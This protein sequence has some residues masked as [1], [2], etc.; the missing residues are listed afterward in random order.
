MFKWLDTPRH[1]CAIILRYFQIFFC[2]RIHLT[3]HRII[4][5]YLY[6]IMYNDHP[7][8][9]CL[10]SYARKNVTSTA[11]PRLLVQTRVLYLNFSFCLLLL[12]IFGK[13]FCSS[14]P[15]LLPSTYTS[16]YMFRV[17]RPV[18]QQQIQHH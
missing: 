4:S 5:K 11:L 14:F 12:F 17:F 6:K 10:S 18:H 8:P 16:V 9:S 1:N 15:F 2:I 7:V 13:A 3:C